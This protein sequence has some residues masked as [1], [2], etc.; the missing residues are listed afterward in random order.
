MGGG[1]VSSEQDERRIVDELNDHML[2]KLRKNAHKP[3]WQ[4][5]SVPFLIERLREE[6]EELHEAYFGNEGATAIAFECA[7]VANIAAMILDN[8][9]EER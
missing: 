2:F 1:E 7:D 3:N 9:K 8:T 5:E 6:V 4:E